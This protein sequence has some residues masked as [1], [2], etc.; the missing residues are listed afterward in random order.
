[1]SIIVA[2][3]LEFVAFVSIALDFVEFVCVSV[4]F[5]VFVCVCVF[6]SSFVHK[7]I[8]NIMQEQ[9][10][11]TKTYENQYKNKLCPLGHNKRKVFHCFSV[12]FH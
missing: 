4:C 1:M 12:G 3:P 2:F 11:S 7:N 6:V 5:C 8:Q 9:V 10:L